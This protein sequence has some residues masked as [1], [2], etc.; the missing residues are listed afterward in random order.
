MSD[1]R[2]QAA[3]RQA[4]S[5]LQ[6]YLSD[7]IAPL[8]AAD[9]LHDLV[10]HPPEI[11]ARAIAQWIQAQFRGPGAQVPVADLV[12]HAVKKLHLL[13]EFDLIA[14]EP[15]MKFL[16]GVSRVLVQAC[17]ES[18]RDEL[19][20]RISRLGETDTAIVS[21]ADFLHRES[22]GEPPAPD[23]RP[24]AETPKAEPA[25]PAP[26]TVRHGARALTLLLER[27]AQVKIPEG[28]KAGDRPETTLLARVLATAALDSRTDADLA[29]HLETVRA[30]GVADSMGK[31]F[32]ALGWS[33]PGWTTVGVEGGESALLQA[34]AGKPL[35]AMNRIV[36]LAPDAQ[37]RAKRWGEMIYAAIEQFNEGRL[38]Q[39][40][41]ILEVARRV[42]EEK[43]PDK[44]IVG[45]VLQQA[46]GAISEQVLRRVVEVPEKHGLVRKV[47]EFFPGL[48]P[49]SLL[50]SLENEL[51]RDR[52]KLMLAMIEVH[53]PGCRD[54]ILKRLA[55]SLDGQVPDPLGYYRRN[56]AFLLRRIPRSKRENLAEELG[57]LERMIARGEPLLSAKEAIGSL[58]QIRHPDAE[59]ILEDRLRSLESESMASG[60]GA[61]AWETLDRICGALARQG[62]T[63]AIRTVCNHAFKRQAA[64]GDTMARLEQLSWNDLSIDP[65]QLAN[66]LKAIHDLIPSRMMQ[67]V[68]RS[69]H[70]L[71]CLIQAISGTPTQE[72]RT[73]LEDLASRFRGQP[74]GEQCAAIVAKFEPR[75]KA[76]AAEALSGDLDLFGLPML[77]QSLGSSQS[78]GDLVLFDRRQARR[79]TIVLSQGRLQR[80]EAGKLENAE[81]VYLLMEDPFPGTFVF[82]AAGDDKAPSRTAL[83]AMSLILEGARR[84][85]E[86]QQAKA[87][88][89]DGIR[90]EPGGADAIR[91][92]DEE[93]DAFA[94]QVWEKA[95]TGVPAE[96]V[97][98]EIAVDPFRVRRLYAHWLEQ[99]AL[100][101]KA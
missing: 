83:D 3:V 65:E 20:L 81:A 47:L 37:E 42:I 32:R 49:Q 87:L 18:Q 44:T 80:A 33:L 92:E 7:D 69:N 67:F 60:G 63:R 29:R 21:R 70:E 48:S 24:L 45:Q 89:P 71:S 76:T 58:G 17:P 77:L 9:A 51:R 35:E 23:A 66:L 2:T 101:V 85:D 74:L 40:V 36:A 100:Q 84:H 46:E 31:V 91:P 8:M 59:R 73:L 55:M 11:A 97:E 62:T 38:A 99:G 56:H 4:A 39:A 88:V 93:D 12:Y 1:D 34:P 79:G 22:T 94:R 43:R 96:E 19:K 10:P 75:S 27:L 13:A 25:P 61:E 95:S 78:T 54:A 26:E 98:R 16:Q 30:E 82:R 50:E 53:G 28:A 57:L 41:S 15:M 5:E 64:L 6:R 72:V 90:L 68:R 52:R 14:R 86:F